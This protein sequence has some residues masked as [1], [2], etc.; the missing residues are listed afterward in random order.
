MI[1]DASETRF[2]QKLHP[3]VLCAIHPDHPFDFSEKGIWIQ[4]DEALKD[5]IDQW[6]HISQEDGDLQGDLRKIFQ[7]NPVKGS[8]PP[9]PAIAPRANPPTPRWLAPADSA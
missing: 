2:Q 4:R 8:A 5:F 3:G 9:R 1:T 7:L 6:L